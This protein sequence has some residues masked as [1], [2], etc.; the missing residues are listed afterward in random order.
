MSTSTINYAIRKYL[1]ALES[2]KILNIYD[3]ENAWWNSM[4]AAYRVKGLYK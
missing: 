1:L 4:A 2:C 3:Y